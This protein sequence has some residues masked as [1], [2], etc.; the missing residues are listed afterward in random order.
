MMRDACFV[1]QVMAFAAVAVALYAEEENMTFLQLGS[2]VDGRLAAGQ[3][4]DYTLELDT[5]TYLRIEVEQRKLDVALELFDPAGVSILKVDSPIGRR[6]IE[7]LLVVSEEQGRYRLRIAAA[8]PEAL[9]GDFQLTVVEQRPAST[10]DRTRAT[11]ALLLSRGDQERRSGKG[12][13]LAA[14]R[15]F[16]ED[17]LE[18]FRA[19]ADFHLEADVLFRL[20]LTNALRGERPTAADQ[21]EQALRRYRTSARQQEISYVLNNLGAVYW[22]LGRKEDARRCFEENLQTTVAPDIR[23]AAHGNLGLMLRQEGELAQA[24]DAHFQALELFRQQNEPRQEI[25][26]LSNIGQ[27]LIDQGKLESARDYLGKALELLTIHVDL[28]RRSQILANRGEAFKREGDLQAAQDDLEAALQ[29]ARELKDGHRIALRLIN[30]GTVHLIAGKEGQARSNFEEALQI[31][32]SLTPPYRIG[33][34]LALHSLGRLDLPNPGQ[35]WS[36]N[37]ARA[38]DYFAAAGAIFGDGGDSQ[39]LISNHYGWALALRALGDLQGAREMLAKSLASVET[40]RSNSGGESLSISFFATKQHYLDLDI[41]LLMQLEAKR[42]QAGFAEL[43]FEASER[44][45]ARALLDVMNGPDPLSRLDTGELA[46]KEKRA[47]S[48]LQELE[49]QRRRSVVHEPGEEGLWEKIRGVQLELDRIR[50]Q[51]SQRRSPDSVGTREPARLAEIQQHLLDEQS[52]LLAYS[53]GEERSFLWLVSKREI[54]SLEL[55]PRREIES[56]AV[57][58]HRELSA[59]HSAELKAQRRI[60]LAKLGQMILGP[61]AGRLE[62][63]RLLIAGDGSL[64]YVPF[65]ALIEPSTNDYLVKRHE[66][67]YLPSASVALAMRKRLA[68]RDPAPRPIVIFADPTIAAA[69]PGEPKYAELPNTRKE[70]QE[71]NRIFAGEGQEFLGEKVSKQNVLSADLSQY[72]ILHF[73]T[74]GEMDNVVPELSGLVLSSSASSSSGD[75]FLRLHEISGLHLAAELVVLSACR[76]AVG[77]AA[78]GEGLLGLT[79]GFLHAGVPRVLASLW[80]ISDHGTAELM[81]RFYWALIEGGASPG[82]ALQAAQLALIAED[83]EGNGLGDPFVWAAF[84]LQGEWRLPGSADD[85]IEP[86]PIGSIVGDQYGIDLPVPVPVPIGCEKLPEP[87]MRIVCALIQAWPLAPAEPSTGFEPPTI[88]AETTRGGIREAPPETANAGFAETRE[89]GDAMVYSFGIEGLSGS[90]VMPPMRESELERRILRIDRNERQEFLLKWAKQQMFGNR[91]P[92]RRP[93]PGVDPKDL[94]SAGWSIV[95]APS[96]PPAVRLALKPLIE[97]RQEQASKVNSSFFKNINYVVGETFDGFQQR[98]KF[99]MGPADPREF[100]YYVLLVGSPAE[101]PFEFQYMLDIQF[102]VGRLYFDTPEEYAAYARGVLLA[103]RGEVDVVPDAALLAIRNGEDRATEA[104]SRGLVTPLLEEAAKKWQGLRIR[105]A[106]GLKSEMLGLL[107]A[108]A[109]PAFLFSSSHGVRWPSGHELQKTHQGALLGSDWQGGPIDL[110]KHCIG[111]PDIGKDARL[112]GLIAF[113]FGC[114]TAGTPERD[115]FPAEA[116]RSPVLAPQPMVA[117]LAQR[118]LGHPNGGAL[119]VIGHIDR[120]WTLSFG[121]PGMGFL[122]FAAFLES[123]ITGHP[124]G[125]A[126]DWLNEKFAQLSAALTDLLDPRG[127]RSPQPTE[128]SRLWRGLNDA[129]N[130]VVLGDPAVRLVGLPSGTSALTSAQS[131]LAVSRNQLAE[132]VSRLS[133]RSS[134]E[135]TTLPT[136]MLRRLRGSRS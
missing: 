48:R 93:A 61:A 96:T 26:T 50:Y 67:V 28:P 81:K 11:A 120:A 18:R 68:F 52:L 3:F 38:R 136:E 119:A 10:D 15:G 91:G 123:L 122:T 105:S 21:L 97:H 92:D 30:L 12:E 42:P 115:N 59:R 129:R 29:L 46:E 84:I 102:A 9:P 116:F 40:L 108:G 27:L 82:R 124:V 47:Q 71:I 6:G 13:N 56:L 111:A 62:R 78:K 22:E 2:K 79:R 80:N 60:R 20:G 33:E 1:L 130:L 39:V 45:R 41:E 31:S 36:G 64:L 125:S 57:Q 103:E 128:L 25:A 43:A 98:I 109:T 94:A 34:A 73:A 54:L 63:K 75:R 133:T 23:A 131:Q 35:G 66:I 53:L 69:Q 132:L 86:A 100:P 135:L 55:P 8:E 112:R 44:R 4:S 113:L 101:I 99:S 65:A 127:K 51:L 32:R 77:P 106:K 126:M 104:C 37:P 85:D 89:D 88:P 5:D 114:H 110:A 95:F 17:A 70:A 74:H 134:P 72:Q 14:A 90:P 121:G 49:L 76:T 87:W 24:L 107:G 16:Y 19:V 117:P 58:L 118:L 7:T 83:P